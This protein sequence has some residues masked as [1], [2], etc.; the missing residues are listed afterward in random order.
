MH[1]KR[2]IQQ[3]SELV[4]LPSVSCAS[5]NLDMSNKAVVDTLASWFE[6]LGFDCRIEPVKDHPGKYN[7][8]AVRGQGDGGVVFAGHT[9]TVPYN[10]ERWQ[11]DPF[12]LTEKNER[13]Y[14][15]GATD[16]KG[17][18]PAVWAALQAFENTEFNE[19]VIII[20]TADEESSMSGARALAEQLMPKARYAIIG[21][22]TEMRPVNMHKGILMEA[23]KIQGKAGHSSNPALGVNAMESMHSVMGELLRYR[24]ELQQKYQNSHFE[25]TVPTLNLG[26]IHGGDSPNRICSACELHF[27]LRMLPGMNIDELRAEFEQ[28]LQPVAE[29][30]GT[31]IIFSTLFAGV[32]AF[33]QPAESELIQ[34]VSQLTQFEPKAVAFAT[35]APYLQSLGMQTV[36]MGPGSIDQAHQANEFI[37][38]SEI[39][40]A[41]KVLEG[42]IRRFCV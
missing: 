21:E 11:Q 2:Y 32:P 28:R 40:P 30:H 39:A 22:P 38:L 27:D 41:V 3:L 25:V 13:L 26:C 10:A 33:E 23:I 8:I 34:T 14:G 12:K 1:I 31:D 4:A 29:Q 6:P 35:E 19:P 17:F 15:L 16:M 37:A 18:F 42:I 9:D 20:A 36:V 24:H 5:P 7:L